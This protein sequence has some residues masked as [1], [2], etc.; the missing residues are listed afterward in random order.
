MSDDRA[1]LERLRKVKRL[2]ELEAKAAAA[3][4]Q[5]NQAQEAG[6]AFLDAA[7]RIPGW[8][9]PQAQALR[10]GATLGFADEITGIVAGDERKA[11]ARRQAR[12][13]AKDHPAQSF[14]LN[15]AGG[16]A[17]AAATGGLGIGA[18]GLGLTAKGTS[19]ARAA[20]VAGIEGG[21]AGAGYAEGGVEERA[22][23]AAFGAVA[24]AA[25]GGTFQKAANAVGRKW[26]GARNKSYVGFREDAQANKTIFR[27]LSDDMGGRSKAAYFLRR[28]AKD[29]SDPDKLRDELLK[30]GNGRAVLLAVNMETKSDNVIGQFRE[31]QRGLKEA[32]KGAFGDT[33]KT[34]KKT[35]FS[36]KKAI[37]FKRQV[38][39]GALFDVVR[40]T[41]IPEREYADVMANL[42][43]PDTHLTKAVRSAERELR[44][45]ADQT[46]FHTLKI[47]KENLDDEIGALLRQGKRARAGRIMEKRNQLRDYLIDASRRHGGGEYEE[48]LAVYTTASRMDEAITVGRNFQK[49]V[50]E[51]GPEA[52]AARL[53][54]LEAAE[55]QYA[56]LGFAQGF[57][58]KLSKTRDYVQFVRFME[59]DDFRDAARVMLA[60]DAGSQVADDLIATLTDIAEKNLAINDV[61]PSTGSNTV[62]KAKADALLKAAAQDRFGDALVE[63]V[64]NPR[65]AGTSLFRKIN[66]QSE[67]ERAR[68]LALRLHQIIYGG[69]EEIQDELV[70]PDRLVGSPAAVGAVTG[71]ASRM[72]APPDDR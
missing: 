11:T 12:Q 70:R 56:T 34:D 33:I 71:A 53:D 58:R 55:R 19:A 10:Q 29:G 39:A 52:L 36:A 7:D 15:A 5:P 2:K 9:S 4:V 22:Q 27:A 26:I 45:K 18:K 14:A 63:T 16:V 69:A 44:K 23:P 35:L 30:G 43:E 49:I 32:A 24:G 1:E 41:P 25:L 21:I 20:A 65:A 66:R 42:V 13:F 57:V 62:N 3:P 37:D 67:Q 28:W 31:M 50:D 51:G 46:P 61:L 54:E 8:A 64:A 60:D 6:G 38:E 72:N 40:R 59:T 48:G 68:S 47:A 17:T